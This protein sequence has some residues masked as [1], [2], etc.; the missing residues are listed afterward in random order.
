MEIQR[1][2]GAAGKSCGDVLLGRMNPFSST[3]LE[4]AYYSV[5]LL[6]FVCLLQVGFGMWN[7]AHEWQGI[8]LHECLLVLPVISCLPSS[9]PSYCVMDPYALLW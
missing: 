6:A 3:H 5:Y 4:S 9:S 7:S 2:V 1:T 8:A